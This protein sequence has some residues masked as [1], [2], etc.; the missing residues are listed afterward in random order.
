MENI[1]IIIHTLTCMGRE[2]NRERKKE[3][4]IYFKGLAHMIM[5]AGKSKITGR[6]SRLEIHA[7]H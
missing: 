5:E 2:R 1:Y 4:K 3:R 7:I 6:A